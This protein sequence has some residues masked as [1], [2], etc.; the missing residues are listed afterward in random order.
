[1]DITLSQ[2]KQKFEQPPFVSFNAAIEMKSKEQEVLDREKEEYFSR[3]GTVTRYS[4]TSVI[5]EQIHPSAIN[6]APNQ[7]RK[8]VWSR[9]QGDTTSLVA[10]HSR[11]KPE[12][13]RM[14]ITE[15]K[16]VSKTVWTINIAGIFYG[17]FETEELAVA[18]R[19]EKRKLLNMP[20]AEY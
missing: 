5:I 13:R 2:L 1:M 14:N 11:N 7:K 15:K 6:Q 19:D 8:K 10:Y 9:G 18:F 16:L 20:V 3:G 12:K 17:S 4:P